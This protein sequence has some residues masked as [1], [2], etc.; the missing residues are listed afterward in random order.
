MLVLIGHTNAPT[1][2]PYSTII[3]QGGSDQL[4]AVAET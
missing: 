3:I 2:A 1:A 4:P